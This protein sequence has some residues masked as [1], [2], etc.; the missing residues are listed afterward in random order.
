MWKKVSCLI[1]LL[2]ALFGFQ[3]GVDAQSKYDYSQELNY[4][5]GNTMEVCLIVILSLEMSALITV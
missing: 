1:V 4:Y 2:L 5:N 3:Q